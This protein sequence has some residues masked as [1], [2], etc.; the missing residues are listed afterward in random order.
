MSQKKLLKKLKKLEKAY[1]ESE[2]K[3][4]LQ[5]RILKTAESVEMK[6]NDKI[7]K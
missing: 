2:G 3:P 7:T 4:L 5:A 1:E 6:L